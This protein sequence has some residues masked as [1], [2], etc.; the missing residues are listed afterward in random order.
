MLLAS[1]LEEM[2]RDLQE[3][4]LKA[5]NSIK[6]SPGIDIEMLRS[7]LGVTKGS[8]SKYISVLVRNG[9]AQYTDNI[10]RNMEITRRGRFYLEKGDPR[11]AFGYPQG[12]AVPDYVAFRFALGEGILTGEVAH[13]Y[14]EFLGLA[15][16]IDSRSLVFHL[17]RGD[18]D[19]WFEEVFRDKRIGGR[20]ARL[21]MIQQ[22]PDKIR[23]KLVSILTERIG[24]IS[25]QKEER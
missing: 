6:A 24:E 13:S 18:F 4:E 14:Q 10:K 20:I 19:A 7:S 16:R 5:L 11:I 22:S 17:Y 23:S 21:K 8:L 2:A 9:L 1:H 25:K 3:G 15:G 12:S